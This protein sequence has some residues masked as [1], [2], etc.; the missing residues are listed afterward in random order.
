MPKEGVQ[1]TGGGV[2]RKSAKDEGRNRVRHNDG[3][4]PAE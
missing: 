3:R 4:G 1:I 2:T